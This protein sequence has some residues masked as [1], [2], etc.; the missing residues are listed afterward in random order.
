[1]DKISWLI[2]KNYRVVRKSWTNYAIV[3]KSKVRTDINYKNYYPKKSKK[4]HPKVIY[5]K[6]GSPQKFF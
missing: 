4:I 6:S 3:P 2:P 1:M 5:Y